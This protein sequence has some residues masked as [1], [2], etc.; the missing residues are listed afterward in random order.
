VTIV[1]Q[2]L[3]RVNAKRKDFQKARESLLD[4]YLK[5][6]P[7]MLSAKPVPGTRL[8]IN[9]QG[10]SDK[11]LWG[12]TGHAQQDP[13]G[14]T[15]SRFDMANS[16]GIVLD[17]LVDAPQYRGGVRMTADNQ[18]D[19]GGLYI[20]PDNSLEEQQR[21]LT[22]CNRVHN[23]VEQPQAFAR[24]KKMLGEFADAFELWGRAVQE[25][26]TADADVATTED[27]LK[28]MRKQLLRDVNQLG[29]E[30]I[31]VTESASTAAV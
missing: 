18:W 5:A 8:I 12:R 20:L 24:R 14:A 28:A 23:E 9:R 22:E 17:S 1:A 21:R 16:V 11:S 25:F 6:N 2:A 7:Q 10:N 13:P 31:D 15:D 4:E 19:K 27:Q 29:Q 3:Q 26:Q 30:P